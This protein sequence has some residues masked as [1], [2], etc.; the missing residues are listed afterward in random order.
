MTLRGQRPRPG[1]YSVLIPR[2][3]IESTLPPQ[4]YLALCLWPN[5]YHPE[6]DAVE[7]FVPSRDL[8]IMVLQYPDLARLAYITEIIDTKSQENVLFSHNTG[9]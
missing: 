7:W 9:I 4:A 8:L 2:E 5:V 1:D 6:P 3:P